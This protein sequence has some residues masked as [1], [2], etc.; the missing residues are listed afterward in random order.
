MVATK[1]LKDVLQGEYLVKEVGVQISDVRGM[2]I[3]RKNWWHAYQRMQLRG[4]SMILILDMLRL[5]TECS[6]NN[7]R[8][9]LAF[10]LELPLKAMC[11]IALVTCLSTC[12]KYLYYTLMVVL[13]CNLQ[14]CLTVAVLHL[15]ISSVLEQK[16][17]NLFVSICSCSR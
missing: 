8:S 1:E 9:L 12:S 6:M 17:H 10:M 4:R 5:I 16:A 11:R 14:W 3:N 15:R 7:V 13:C 2:Y